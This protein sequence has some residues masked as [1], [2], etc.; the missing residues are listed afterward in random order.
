[1]GFLSS[2]KELINV[3]VEIPDFEGALRIFFTKFF[4][5]ADAASKGLDSEMEGF[6]DRVTCF[7]SP[8]INRERPIKGFFFN[9]YAFLLD[10]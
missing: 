8:L 5:F 4:L 7:I 9:E 1:M 2:Y 3:F 10:I 6:K